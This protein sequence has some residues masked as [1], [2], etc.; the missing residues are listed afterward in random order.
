MPAPHVNVKV[1]P[2]RSGRVTKWVVRAGSATYGPVGSKS[3]AER[4]AAGYVRKFGGRVVS[5][6]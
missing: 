4:I 2:V 5:P 3:E 1:V 6:K